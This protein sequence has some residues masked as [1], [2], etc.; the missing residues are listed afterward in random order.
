MI[1]EVLDNILNPNDGE[2]VTDNVGVNIVTSSEKYG[3][4]LLNELGQQQQQNITVTGVNISM[5]LLWLCAVLP[6]F[7]DIFIAVVEGSQIDSSEHEDGLFF[8]R[9]ELVEFSSS[10]GGQDGLNVDDSD[11]ELLPPASITLPPQLLMEG[12]ESLSVVNLL[13]MNVEQFFPTNK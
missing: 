2:L 5:S 1:V 12:A 9:P 11:M 13:V 10:G 4:F 7:H 6:F 3:N 8:P